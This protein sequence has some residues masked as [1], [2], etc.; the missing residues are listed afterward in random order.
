MASEI[1]DAI[2]NPVAF[3]QDYDED[4]LEAEL[5]DLEAEVEAQEQAQLDQ[6]LLS[7]GPMPNVPNTKLPPAA[8]A[9]A[10][11]DEDEMIKQLAAWAT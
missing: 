6:D 3:G 9:P 4:D 1:A 5:G 7:I 10:K 8:V 11:N 2:S